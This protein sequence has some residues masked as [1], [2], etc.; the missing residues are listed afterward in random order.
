MTDGNST[1]QALP[2]ELLVFNGIDIE[3]GDYLS[4]PCSRKELVRSALS[5]QADKQHLAELA[6]KQAAGAGTYLGILG[7]FDAN[8]LSEA[9]WGFLAAQEESQDVLDALQPLF[10]LRRE[11]TT[12]ADGAKRFYEYSG[13]NGHILGE[14]K[15]DF[16]LR[17]LI[18]S[19]QVDPREAPYYLLI[20]GS[21]ERI[22][23]QFQFEMDLNFA[24]GRLHFDTPDEYRHYAQSVV[25]FERERLK[26]TRS[27]ALFGTQHAEDP[28]TSLSRTSLIE[29]LA[30][31]LGTLPDWK[32]Q[33]FAGE[34]ATKRRLASLL[35]G[36]E[37]PA[38]LFTATHG[39]V[40]RPAKPSHREVNGALLC[41]EWPFRN[42]AKENHY[43]AAGDVAEDAQLHGLIVFHFACFSAGTPRV[44]Q[45]AFM[46]EFQRDPPTEL[47]P[48][49]FLARLPQ[50]ML[51]HPQGGALAVVGHVDRALGHST[52]WP[53]YERGQFTGRFLP[54]IKEYESALKQLLAGVP[55][56]CAMEPFGQRYADLASQ[57]EEERGEVLESKRP[58]DERIISL[59]AGKNDAR[60]F[61]VLGDPAVRINT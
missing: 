13:K 60:A 9:G 19:G 54:S 48:Q 8:M 58:D 12:R 39:A 40:Q 44:N 28:A 5:S 53:I 46:P 1:S 21:P 23:F 59:W 26:R 51:G 42:P 55:I 37:T 36:T 24:V 31:E 38:V 15:R 50:R 35:G 27:V 11:Q 49:S 7:G 25:R 52:A 47:T 22:P 18:P 32:T 56:G 20:I 14:T 4:P 41:Q 57:L 10:E 34:E 33:C 3:S 61:V 6:Q 16:V 30:T 43:F 45:Y 2:S 29:P 17:N